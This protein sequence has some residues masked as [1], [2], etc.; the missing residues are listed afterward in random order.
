[1]EGPRQGVSTIPTKHHRVEI[2]MTLNPSA[3][4]PHP[5]ALGPF[6]RPQQRHGNA[7]DG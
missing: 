3:V 2:Q 1:M 6:N 7:Q 5:P 4:N